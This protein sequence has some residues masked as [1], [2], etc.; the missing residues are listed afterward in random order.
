MLG[1]RKDLGRLVQ[2]LQPDEIVVAIIHQDQIDD[3]LFRT[4]FACRALG[5]PVTTM[6]AV[7]ERLTGRVEALRSAPAISTS[8]SRSNRRHT[9]GSTCCCAA[10]STSRVGLGGCVLVAALVPGVWLANRWSSPGDDLLPAGAGGQGR[11]P[12]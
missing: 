8:C 11:P 5:I 10:P 4:I 1:T 12:L 2:Q 6:P 9:C 7:Y 3:D